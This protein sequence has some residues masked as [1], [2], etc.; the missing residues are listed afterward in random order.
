METIRAGKGLGS[1]QVHPPQAC[2]P[3]VAA[4]VGIVVLSELLIGPCTNK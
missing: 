1:H 3:G 2:W 4:A